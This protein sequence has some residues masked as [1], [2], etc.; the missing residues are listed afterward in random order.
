M[1]ADIPRILEDL[2]A[3]RPDEIGKLD[4]G[5]L[6]FTGRIINDA[7]V[8]DHHA[9]IP[10][11]KPP[12]ALSPIGQKVYDAV[13]TRL[14]AAFYPACVKEVTTVSG[15]FERGAVPGQGRASARAGLDRTLPPQR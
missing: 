13:V 4:L 8:G 6:T 11:G 14:I 10:T 2:R 7:K 15:L 1:K 9:I 3:I 12:A 5:A